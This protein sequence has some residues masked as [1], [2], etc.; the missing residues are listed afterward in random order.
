MHKDKDFDDLIFDNL[1]EVESALLSSFDLL[2]SVYD[3]IDAGGEQSR[4]FRD[5][6]SIL[7]RLIRNLERLVR[8]IHG[9]TNVYK[10]SVVRRKKPDG[11]VRTGRKSRRV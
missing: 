10:N 11:N 4:A 2:H 9:V 3:S 8:K 1:V 7:K 5:E 6:L